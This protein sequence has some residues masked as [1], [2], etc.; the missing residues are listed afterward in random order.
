MK[1]L[2]RIAVI[3]L[4]VSAPTFAATFNVNTSTDTQDAMPGNGVC[5]DSASECSF[6]AAI[7][8]ANALS[9]NDTIV[10]PAGIITQRLVS[11]DDNLNLGGDWD[12][13][14]N[15]AIIGAGQGSTTLQAGA[16][17]NSATERVLEIV[18]GTVSITGVTIRHGSFA[19][20]A[21]TTATKGG[22][23]RNGGNLTLT[24][25]TVTANRS[26]TGGGIYNEGP[27]IELTNVNVTNNSV[28]CTDD[29]CYG[30]GFYSGN[31]GAA[32][33]GS[34]TI[35][36]SNFTGNTASPTGGNDSLAGGAGINGEYGFN[37]QV[38]GSN[39]SNNTAEYGGGLMML[40]EGN[41]PA[42]TRI[43][44]TNVTDSTFRQNTAVVGGGMYFLSIAR[45]TITGTAARNTIDANAGGGIAFITSIS[46]D[47]DVTIDS[48]TI[49]NNQ[50]G[51]GGGAVISALTAQQDASI[52][53]NFLN[54][55]ISG[56]H[57]T[58]EG[59]GV[60]AQGGKIGASVSFGFNFCTVVNNSIAG[61]NVPPPT[62]GFGGGGVRNRF[63][64]FTVRNSVIADNTVAAG[65]VGPDIHGFWASQNYNL[66]E[67]VSSES[68]GGNPA[69]DLRGIDPVL[70]ALANNGGPTFTHMPQI[71]SPVIDS[72]PNGANNCGTTVTRDQRVSVSRPRGP[73]CDRGSIEAVLFGPWT[74]SGTVRTA[75]GL[76]VRNAIVVLTGDSLPGPLLFPTATFG[77]YQF[78]GLPPGNYTLVI[79][80]KR[81]SFDPRQINLE[82]NE[83]SFDLIASGED[84]RLKR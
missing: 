64:S 60:F 42:E 69:N 66:I 77:V 54:S 46:G 55:T 58:A 24:N 51:L 81:Y 6:R 26:R 78:S 14:S 32:G 59:G 35:T 76:P 79:N 13:T 19:N 9:G 8:E 43:F 25:S 63:S 83:L 44:N 80:S 73:G 7:D 47:I 71:G 72:I 18:S 21:A 23:I 38:T 17:P 15:I 31:L 75:G 40:V 12:I 1:V 48:S 36:G 49:S 29:R 4:A 10:L 52:N 16:A 20:G 56:N 37:L 53:V 39:F 33:P 65:G 84:A 5:A 30:G 68:T 3:I 62:S 67:N 22:G 45:A 2:F 27:L 50:A 34:A 82:Q 74:L 11:P 41:R 57:A 28:Q 61:I 70:G